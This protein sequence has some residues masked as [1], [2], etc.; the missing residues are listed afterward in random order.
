MAA[1]F[2]AVQGAVAVDEVDVIYLASELLRHFQTTAGQGLLFAGLSRTDAGDHLGVAGIELH[3]EV[4]AV[5]G[6]KV[7]LRLRSQYIWHDVEIR[8]RRAPLSAVPETVEER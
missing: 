6:N 4:V 3:A 2:I 1:G 5:E 8:H 7:R